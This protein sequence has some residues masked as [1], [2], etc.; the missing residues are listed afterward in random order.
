MFGTHLLAGTLSCTTSRSLPGCWE[1]HSYLSFGVLFF[2]IQV[3]LRVQA[4]IYTALKLPFCLLL[5]FQPFFLVYLLPLP[6]FTRWLNRFDP[7]PI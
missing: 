3:R 5:L 6:Y 7:S 2:T 4:F 1:L